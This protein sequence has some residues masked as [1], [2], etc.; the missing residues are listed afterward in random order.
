[1]DLNLASLD[2]IDIS[3]AEGKNIFFA[4]D[5]HLG[6]PDGEKS[7]E[8]ERRLIAWIRNNEPQM[9]EL[10]LLGDVFDFWFEYGHAVPKGALRF[11]GELARLADS[12]MPIRIFAGNHDLWYKEYFQ[13]ELGASIY[14]QPIIL[15]VNEGYSALVGHGDGL[16]PGDAGYKRLKRIFTN[17][18][19]KWAFA[20]I[21][22]NAGIAIAR[23]WSAHSRSHNIDGEQVFK[24]DAEWLWQFAR[25]VEANQHFDY[26]VFGHRHL[27]LDLPVGT[28]SRYINT[29]EWLNKNSFAYANA[30]GIHL[31]YWV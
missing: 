20:R 12:G 8:R 23:K 24:G 22:P 7:R 13:E 18:F 26:Y 14:H 11:Q 16:G 15:R 10:W 31:D 27:A 30:Q 28:N 5:F 17:R 21:H 29:G 3:L 25:E 9:Q 19:C 4:S 1:M 2:Q 6:A